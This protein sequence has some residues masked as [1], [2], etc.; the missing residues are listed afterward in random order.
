MSN[1]IPYLVG[2]YPNGPDYSTFSQQ[3]EAIT[4]WWDRP[5]AM[6]VLY[7]DQGQLIP[8]WSGEANYYAGYLAGSVAAN[9]IPVIG[10][11][12]YSTADTANTSDQQLIAFANGTFDYAIT[13]CMDAYTN[14]GYKEQVWRLGWEMNLQGGPWYLGNSSNVANSCIYWIEAF[15]HIAN[16]MR[17]HAN[18]TGV[19]VKIVWNP[20]ATSWSNAGRADLTMW[21]GAEYV[22]YVGLD[23]YSQLWPQVSATSANGES[24][25]YDWSSDTNIPLGQ[26]IENPVNREYNWMYPGANEWDYT[27]TANGNQS[28]GLYDC[29]QLCQSNNLPLCLPETGVMDVTDDAT[30]VH[31]DHYMPTWLASTLADANVNVAFICIWDAGTTVNN[32]DGMWSLSTTTMPNTQFAYAESFGVNST[33]NIQAMW[34][35]EDF[36][37]SSN[38]SNGT[39]NTSNTGNTTMS[40]NMVTMTGTLTG[41]IAS[42]NGFVGGTFVGTFTGCFTPFPTIS[43]AN[44]V[45]D[46][47]AGGQG[48]GS[49]SF[50]LSTSQ[51][52]D[53][54]LVCIEGNDTGTPSVEDGDNLTWKTRINQPSSTAG[55]GYIALLWAHS[56][57]VMSNNEITI[58]LGG[59][60][61]G[62]AVAKAVNGANTTNPFDT[63]A[64]LPAGSENSTVEVSTTAA[65]TMI[66]GFYR[67]SNVLDP[68]APGAPWTS[69]DPAANW[70]APYFLDLDQVVNTPQTNLTIPNGGIAVN[71]GIGDAL[72]AQIIIN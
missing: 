30:G 22:D 49:F 63:N 55:G 32:D 9:T 16:T 70:P 66:V 56:A 42:G 48:S 11:P 67:A 27:G 58:N 2:A 54:V 43:Y 23:L 38:T 5:P 21:P 28:F 35:A 8:D 44:L 51:P 53:I 13:G 71:G 33:A 45:N 60:S 69:L 64:S 57:N 1:T 17:S 68:A 34:D 18:T 29:I 40:N 26:W 36:F 50:P 31:D 61:W 20:G 14:N 7:V 25:Y 24:L 37:P 46:G 4:A 12:M 6:Q 19:E 15:Q 62:C 41:N 10:F 52:N 72:V 39:S 47:F 3:F 59:S 65:N